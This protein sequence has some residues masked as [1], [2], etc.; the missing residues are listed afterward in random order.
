[1]IARDAIS[2]SDT[3]APAFLVGRLAIGTVLLDDGFCILDGN[4]V[5]L[6]ELDRLI[7]LF[8]GSIRFLVGHGMTPELIASASCQS[9]FMIEV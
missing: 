6:G 2:S 8:G 5:L 9:A 1:M 3:H 7:G 4:A